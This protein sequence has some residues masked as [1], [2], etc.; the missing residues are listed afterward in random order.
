MFTFINSLTHLPTH[1]VFLKLSIKLDVELHRNFV[2]RKVDLAIP[3]AQQIIPIL[4]PPT[5]KRKKEKLASYS[6][7]NESHPIHV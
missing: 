7:S 6:Q 1:Y 4:T 3:L 2:G 5:K